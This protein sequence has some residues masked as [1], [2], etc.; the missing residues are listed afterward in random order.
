MFVGGIVQRYGMMMCPKCKRGVGV[1]PAGKCLFCGSDDEV[2]DPIRGQYEPHDGELDV[3][4]KPP[5]ECLPEN[6]GIIAVESPRGV[7]FQGRICRVCRKTIREG[8]SL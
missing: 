6:F 4:P 7:E 3:I 2:K 8:E 5:H 1:V